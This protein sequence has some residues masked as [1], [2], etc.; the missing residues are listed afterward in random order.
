VNNVVRALQAFLGVNQSHGIN[1]INIFLIVASFIVL[2]LSITRIIQARRKNTPVATHLID[3]G[4][5]LLGVGMIWV[6]YATHPEAIPLLH[7][8][9][10]T[11]FIAILGHGG[12]SLLGT[13]F[14]VRMLFAPA[15]KDPDQR[16]FVWSLLLLL[17][18]VGWEVQHWPSPMIA[19]GEAI[20]LTFAIIAYFTVSPPNII[21]WQNVIALTLYVALFIWDVTHHATGWGILAIGGLFLPIAFLDTL[22]VWSMILVLERTTDDAYK[23]G[24]AAESDWR[25][26]ITVTIAALLGVLGALGAFNPVIRNAD[27]TPIIWLEATAVTCVFLLMYPLFQ[28]SQFRLED[29][30]SKWLSEQQLQEINDANDAAMK[31]LDDITK[32]IDTIQKSQIGRGFWQRQLASIGIGANRGQEDADLAKLRS[33]KGDIQ[34]KLRDQAAHREQ[35]KQERIKD[36]LTSFGP[37]IAFGIFLYA[38][39]LSF[40]LLLG[41]HLPLIPKHNYY[42]LVLVGIVSVVNWRVFYIGYKDPKKD[43]KQIALQPLKDSSQAAAFFAGLFSSV[44]SFAPQ[45]DWFTFVQRFSFLAHL[46]WTLIFTDLHVLGWISLVLL[47][48]GQ[49]FGAYIV[50]GLRRKIDRLSSLPISNQAAVASVVSGASAATGHP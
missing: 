48:F 3:G 36:I 25:R 18:P 29:N 16:V 8:N 45:Q 27:F 37:V 17:P 34:K 1:L 33:Q 41:L 22:F 28:T 12:F 42:T 43:L 38:F 11:T 49:L 6:S 30:I 20:L 13:F 35:A 39:V 5:A 9:G 21:C 24:R 47:M 50:I 46:D 40:H 14:L 26:F 23:Y 2:L 7:A 32:K 19:I 10:F 4:L 44:F 31:Q 15:L